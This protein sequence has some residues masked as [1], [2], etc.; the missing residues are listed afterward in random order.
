M[1]W[2]PGSFPLHPQICV[3]G[4]EG[5]GLSAVLLGRCLV[6]QPLYCSCS[7]PQGSRLLQGPGNPQ[8]LKLNHG[9]LNHPTP[10]AVSS[11]WVLPQNPHHSV[12]NE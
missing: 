6:S 2:T 12:C 9:E 5:V 3:T 10:Q 11:I 8:C 1:W 4:G 7:L